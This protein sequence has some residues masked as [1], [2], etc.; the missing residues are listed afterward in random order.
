MSGI[1]AWV[2]THYHGGIPNGSSIYLNEADA[3][4]DWDNMF[5]A[6]DI[7]KYEYED[8]EGKLLTAQSAW[9]H[10][11]CEMH[12]E[13]MRVDETIIEGTGEHYRG[14]ER[15]NEK[16]IIHQT[17]LEDLCKRLI[18]SMDA[19]VNC[20]KE[21]ADWCGFTPIGQKGLKEHEARRILWPEDGSIKTWDEYYNL[22]YRPTDTIHLADFCHASIELIEEKG[23]VDLDDYDQQNLLHYCAMWNMECDIG[24]MDE[25]DL[26]IAQNAALMFHKRGW[27]TKKQLQGWG[28]FIAEEEVKT[29][30]ITVPEDA[31]NILSEAL[32]MDMDSKHIDPEIR[33]EIYEAMKQVVVE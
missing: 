17:I 27:A 30:T 31:W 22:E 2:I 5:D 7:A 21:F 10:G 1:K 29:L 12:K 28:D 26:A 4:V 20:R 6:E 33:H 15:Y 8:H 24:D 18:S 13:E 16:D 11:W 32:S 3:R 19:H 14:L 23:V 9:D 25:D